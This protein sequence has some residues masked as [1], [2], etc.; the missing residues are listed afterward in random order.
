MQ[1]PPCSPP[2]PLFLLQTDEI[3]QRTIREAFRGCTV[4][5]IAHRLNTIIDSDK[6]L[7][8][9]RGNLMEF[10]SPDSLLAKGEGGHFY[11]LVANAGG[12][13]KL[14]SG[15]DVELE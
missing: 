14:Q 12:L 4:L 6:I 9:D 11:D 1:R 10:D 8:L 5:T 7:V 15:E 2:V 13:G 3:I